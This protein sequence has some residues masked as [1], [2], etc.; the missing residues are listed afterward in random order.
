MTQARPGAP[1]GDIYMSAFPKG[2]I[3]GPLM[4]LALIAALALS[5]NATSQ[6]LHQPVHKKIHALAPRRLIER[7]LAPGVEL[8]TSTYVNGG[9]ENHYY[10]DT[11]AATHTDLMDHEYRYGQAPSP[12]Y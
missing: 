3:F 5:A 7:P 10:S 11:I 9:S 2:A 12:Q 6:A 8:Q 1:T 4:A